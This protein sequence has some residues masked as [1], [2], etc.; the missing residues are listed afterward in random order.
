[1]SDIVKTLREYVAD[2][3]Y[4]EHIDWAVLAAAADEIQ[5]LSV[6]LGYLENI[7]ECRGEE[8]E[9]LRR[10]V[11]YPQNPMTTI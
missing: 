3:P 2:E 5:R 9:R 6:A 7:A 4:S 11:V 8:N 10:R 1:M